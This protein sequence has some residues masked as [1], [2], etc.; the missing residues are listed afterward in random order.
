M[1][2]NGAY[3]WSEQWRFGKWLGHLSVT[4]CEFAPIVYRNDVDEIPVSVLRSTLRMEWTLRIDA[5]GRLCL[6]ARWDARR[7]PRFGK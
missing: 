3:P 7:R 2:F 5:E 1:D 4:Q 6:G